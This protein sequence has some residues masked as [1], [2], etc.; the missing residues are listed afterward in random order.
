MQRVDVARG[1][2]REHD[3]SADTRDHT[4]RG[5]E[6]ASREEKQS[7]RA[8]DAERRDEARGKGRTDRREVPGVPRPAEQRGGSLEVRNAEGREHRRGAQEDEAPEESPAHPQ[9][10]KLV[11]APVHL[12]HTRRDVAARS[13]SP[14]ERS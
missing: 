1:V 2:L 3:P 5:R 6:D 9:R 10:A 12:G 13:A 8:Q 14:G 7:E 4:G 11:P